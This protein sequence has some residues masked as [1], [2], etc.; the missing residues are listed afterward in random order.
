[1][2]SKYL[3]TKERN[4]IV[5]VF[6]E[7]HPDPLFFPKGEW[8][9]LKLGKNLENEQGFDALRDAKLLIVGP[10]VDEEEFATTER[11]LE[12]KLSQPTILYLM[13][14]QG[15][16]MVCG[17]CP[18]PG[19][20]KKYGASLL[21]ASD[22]VA[23]INLWLEHLKESYNPTTSYFVI[24]YGGEPLLN[25]PT[26]RA[27][28]DHIARLRAE[29]NA[30]PEKLNLMI[31]TNGLLMDQEMISLCKEHGIM[32]AVG[33]DG[34]REVHDALK[35]DTQGLGTFERIVAVIRMLVVQGVR[36]V[37]STTIT[38]FNIGRM[39]DY[40]RFFEELGVEKF[41]FNFLKGKALLELVGPDGQ[42]N[43]Y[44]Q[45]AR[46]VIEH[47]RLQHRTGFE[48]QMEKKVLAF[49][50][51][52]FF[53]VDCTCYG[54]QLVIQPDGQISNCPF[55]KACLGQVG[56]ITPEFRISEQ[57]IVHSWRKR[58]PLYHSGAAKA[59][60]GGGC[61]W[62]SI[63]VNGTPSTEDESSRIFSEEALD[64]LIWSRYD[65][66]RTGQA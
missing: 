44:R 55:Y 27:S 56:T 29:T 16:N 31:A 62:S 35:V 22:A 21:S 23:G 39:K 47:A 8:E 6:H 65:K 26:I 11:H 49:N 15:C 41:G 38:P 4:G 25:K 43:Y 57:E 46:G 1:M 2:W 30:L 45:A 50:Q 40:S 64:E 48:Y 66:L 12:R 33:L 20:A 3:C 51:R 58:L 9:R 34:P 63:E 18:V 24:F 61:A 14:A 54:N 13:T 53:P 59:L 5:A 37:V 32:V 52:D 17:Y 19:L 36:T 7:L 60:S 42:K 28:I 10:E